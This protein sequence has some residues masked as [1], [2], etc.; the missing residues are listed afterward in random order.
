MSFVDNRAKR[1]TI[2]NGKQ[3]IKAFVLE[4]IN[5]NN[6]SNYVDLEKSC[7]T[8]IKISDI[9]RSF[10]IFETD[11]RSLITSLFE[12]ETFINEIT[13][14]QEYYNPIS[15][16]DI[17]PSKKQIIPS[18][19]STKITSSS[20]TKIIHSSSSSS[21]KKIENCK[22]CNAVDGNA[23]DQVPKYVGKKKQIFYL[24]KSNWL[25]AYKNGFFER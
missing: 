15:T 7:F 23:I 12:N 16:Q 21:K 10:A 1:M 5:E 8:D 25:S 2:K 14:S 22:K 18:T 11:Y 13:E 9:Q 17:S 6:T 19:S 3:H 24:K 20:S 4:S